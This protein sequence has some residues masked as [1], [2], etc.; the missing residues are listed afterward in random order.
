MFTYLKIKETIEEDNSIYSFTKD[1]IWIP[2]LFILDVLCALF[3][4]LFCLMYKRW[5][6]NLYE[7]ERDL[8]KKN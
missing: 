5:Q 1:L 8:W 2:I 4:P 7:N 6:E 3:Q